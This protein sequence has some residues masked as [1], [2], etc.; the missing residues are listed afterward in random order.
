MCLLR[1]AAEKM[2]EEFAVPS[3]F[4]I[5]LDGSVDKSGRSC[6]VL[7]CRGFEA[8]SEWREAHLCNSCCL[9]R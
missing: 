7:R 2:T 4:A 5:E 1:F 9:K 3:F 8:T 6:F